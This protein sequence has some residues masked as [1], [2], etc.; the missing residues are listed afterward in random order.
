MKGMKRYL[1]V[2]LVLGLI[3]AACSQG[4]S[5]ETEAPA[6]TEA[7]AETEAPMEV[8]TDGV[9]VT[10]D[11]IYVGMLADLTGFFANLVGQIVDAERFYFEEYNATTGGIG[12]QY[13][14]EVLVEDTGYDVTAHGE[15]YDKLVDQ[16]VAFTQSTGSPHTVSIAERLVADSRFAIPLSW[17]SG[18]LF[19]EPVGANV[20]EQGT[21]YCL[22]SMNSLEYVAEL[23][24]AENGS[25]PTVAI[26]SWPGEY[27]MDNAMGAMHA[28]EELGLEV[29]Y[30]GAGAV[31]PFAENTEVIQAL[32]DAQPDVVALTAFPPD[33]AAIV[34]GTTQQGLID[35]WF[36]G[37]APTFDAA[38]LASPIGPQLVNRWFQPAPYAPYPADVEGMQEIVDL[39]NKYAPDRA[40]GEAFT[41]GVLEAKI[42]IAVLEAAYAAGDLTP[43]GVLAAAKGLESIDFAELQAAQSW[44]GDP[45]DFAVRASG[46]YKPSADYQ[47]ATVA[48][49]VP[50]LV[51]LETEY[52]GDVAAAYD[53]TEP[54]FI[55]EG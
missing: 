27:G 38:L 50:A 33:L 31:A 8:L 49:A 55:P 17:Y 15:A 52:V 22:E 42:M 23:W 54:C 6:A 10:D 2:V 25:A 5:D 11:T 36:T 51:V 12:G 1:A 39:M 43:E 20:L 48:T 26:A 28:A 14:I 40:S 13:K 21:S 46:M 34:G 3:A 30:N 44:A 37:G 4:A 53:L 45:N 35:A 18:W 41:R 16:V 29:V 19:D 9:T 47:P 32:V 7:P 24:E